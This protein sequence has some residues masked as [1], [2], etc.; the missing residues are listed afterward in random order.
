M[1]LKKAYIGGVHDVE[2]NLISSLVKE[3]M[4]MY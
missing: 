3:G 4:L 2:P 1:S